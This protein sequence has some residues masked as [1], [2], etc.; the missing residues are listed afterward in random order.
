[1]EKLLNEVE[2][3]V[4]NAFKRANKD[5][6]ALLFHSSYEAYG[7]LAEKMAE[8]KGVFKCIEEVLDT[9]FMCIQ[10]GYYDS[11]ANQYLNLI[12][13]NSI[14]CAAKMIRIAATAQKA[15]DSNAVRG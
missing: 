7:V 8:S 15:I 1:M 12:K 6:E 9:V 2:Q 4:E 14:Y 13:N 11:L 3:E 10:N 5:K